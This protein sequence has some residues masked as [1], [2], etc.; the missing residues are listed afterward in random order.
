MAATLI[1][2]DRGRLIM[3]SR[4][5]IHSK[6]ATHNVRE[7]F[8]GWLPGPSA[9]PVFLVDSQSAAATTIPY[10]RYIAMVQMPVITL[11]IWAQ[12]VKIAAMMATV[13]MALAGTLRPL[14][15]AS[16]AEPGSCPSRAMAQTIRL[17]VVTLANPQAKIEINTSNIAQSVAQ[18]GRFSLMMYNN[19]VAWWL[20]TCKDGIARVKPTRT[21]KPSSTE[22]TSETTMAIGMCLWGSTVSSAT[23]AAASKPPIVHALIKA[24]EANAGK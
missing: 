7:A 16:H 21:G 18:G 20:A 5:S 1:H 12:Q 6:A 15:R 23:L 2:E 3:P 8:T 22:A 4:R 24:E 14:T 11:S 9:V 17:N 13:Q 10:T 19:G